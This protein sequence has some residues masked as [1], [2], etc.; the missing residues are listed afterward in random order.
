[1]TTHAA[2]H[3]VTAL[4]HYLIA[5]DLREL[6]D[7]PATSAATRS[8]LTILDALLDDDGE[9]WPPV[10]DVSAELGTAEW[11]RKS[12]D[13]GFRRGE[14]VSGFARLSELRDLVRDGLPLAGAAEETSRNLADWMRV[15]AENICREP[16][17][18][19]PAAVEEF[20]D[21]LA[22]A[23]RVRPVVRARS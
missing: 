4:Y 20:G 1:M 18:D 10:A 9:W 16:T 17:R 7:Q 11:R 15:F 14:N 8:I 3:E 21:A 19:E 6:L 23:S 2:R 22:P 5:G 12:R 13:V